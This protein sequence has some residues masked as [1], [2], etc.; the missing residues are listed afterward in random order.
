MPGFSHLFFMQSDGMLWV[1]HVICLVLVLLVALGIYPE[2]STPIAFLI[3]LSYIHRGSILT[4]LF[5]PVLCMLLLYLSLAPK[6]SLRS[7]MREGDG[8][9]TWRANVVTRLIQVHLC[10][11]YLLIG[12]SKLGTP[13]WWT[14]E[15]S[16]FLITDAQQRLVDV[17][18][19]SERTY[20]LNA[21]THA[22]VL[23]DLLYPL[24]IWNRLARPLLIAVSL[25]V[26]LWTG[27]VTG[28]VGFAALM[29]V[30]NLAFVPAETVA[31]WFGQL[32]ESQSAVL[33]SDS[34]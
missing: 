3:V 5:E 15:A 20:L 19:L 28:L 6:A 24:L 27:M 13:V 7:L 9:P 16:W 26:W 10:G 8:P 22:W 25:L 21:I 18:L 4:G 1:A 14:G 33:G 2:V 23:F 31:S 17:S 30:A 32:N 34:A 12:L 11:F 29:I